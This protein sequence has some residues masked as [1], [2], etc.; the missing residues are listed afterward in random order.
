MGNRSRVFFGLALLAFVAAPGIVRADEPVASA[1]IPP[2]QPSVPLPPVPPAKPLALAPVT[3]M[4]VTPMTVTPTTPA[5]KPAPPKPA[6]TEADRKPRPTRHAARMHQPLRYL[7]T[8]QFAGKPAPPA[9]PRPTLRRYYYAGE[10]PPGF[11]T[12]GP[13]AWYRYYPAPWRYAPY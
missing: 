10:P 4:T 2:P 12:E 11:E 8:H 3:P 5:A 7:S 6:A 1:P 13:P 9:Q